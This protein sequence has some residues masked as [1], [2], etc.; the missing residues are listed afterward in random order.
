MNACSGHLPLNMHSKTSTSLRSFF[1]RSLR[2]NFL[3]RPLSKTGRPTIC[4]ERYR[5]RDSEK[6]PKNTVLEWRLLKSTPFVAE[7]TS[8]LRYHI[9]IC[10][11]PRYLK[12]ERTVEWGPKIPLREAALLLLRAP[13]FS[14][15]NNS[16]EKAP[17]TRSC[18]GM[19][20]S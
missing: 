5:S 11:Q 6:S 15:L 13:F 19:A 4:L 14:I 20:E 17:C 12:I 2:T 8:L 1:F 18:L 7:N 10:Y 16:L 9:P 3:A